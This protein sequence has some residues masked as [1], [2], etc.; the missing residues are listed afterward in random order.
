MLDV[1]SRLI[2]LHGIDMMYSEPAVTI[3]IISFN[4]PYLVLILQNVF[5][6][7]DTRLDDAGASMGASPRRV[8]LAHRVSAG[9]AG[10]SIAAA[11]CFILS[12]NTFPTAVLLGGPRFQMMTAAA[13]FTR[14]PATTT[15]RS[16][17]RSH[18][19]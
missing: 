14:S 10:I 6:G 18:S 17:G 4:L 5:E 9:P 7:I 3:G 2:G 19:S 15:G 12:M 8:F 11:L 16:P 13:V 1:V